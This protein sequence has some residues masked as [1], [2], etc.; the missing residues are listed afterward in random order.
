MDN[1]AGITA[2]MSS[3]GQA[4]HAENENHPVSRIIMLKT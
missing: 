4:F 1:K 3:F 2:L